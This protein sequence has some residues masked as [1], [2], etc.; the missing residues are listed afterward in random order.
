MAGVVDTAGVEVFFGVAI[1]AEGDRGDHA[2]VC[3]RVPEEFFAADL[4]RLPLYDQFGLG[5]RAA[6]ALGQPQRVVPLV[7]A[8]TAAEAACG[9]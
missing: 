3:C 4:Q 9:L 8:Q 6:V 7:L 1:G 5:D 2:G